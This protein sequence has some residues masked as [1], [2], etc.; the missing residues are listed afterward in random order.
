MTPQRRAW[1]AAV[2]GFAAAVAGY[3]A[4]S[5]GE[6]AVIRA[7]FRQG[8]AAAETGDIQAI[9]DLLD[10]DF[11]GRINLL[12]SYSNNYLES[13]HDRRSSLGKD[14]AVEL[15]E[16]AIKGTRDRQVKIG[17]LSIDIE[18]DSAQ[19]HCEFSVKAKLEA[20]V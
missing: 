19:V 5:G 8:A 16:R 6:D 10:D 18:G 1:I 15:I 3:F 11:Q 12:A 9:A 17:R 20:L 2:A 4:F 13:N 7:A 14:E